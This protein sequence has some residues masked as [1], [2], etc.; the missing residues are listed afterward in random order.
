MRNVNCRY[1]DSIGSERLCSSCSLNEEHKDLPSLKVIV[2][3]QKK[4]TPKQIAAQECFQL[5]KS[6]KLEE[7]TY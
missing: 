4:L 1:C 3:R 5:I 7:V 2:R 6:L